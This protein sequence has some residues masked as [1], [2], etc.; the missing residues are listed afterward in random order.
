HL[1]SYHYNGNY[2][3]LEESGHVSHTYAYDSLHNRT[4]HN[5][6][7]Y[8]V[9]ALHSVLHDGKQQ[10]SYDARGN[11]TATGDTHYQYDGLDRLIEVSSP[12]Q[13][14][15]YSYDAFDRRIE[16]KQYTLEA[17]D[18]KLEHSERYI[19]TGQ[20]EIGCVDA[21]GR[22]VQ[23][24]VLGEGLGAEIGAAVAIELENFLHVPIHDHR[25]NVVA[26]LSP[27]GDVV[28][29]YR[30]DAYGNEEIFSPIDSGNPWRF[31][32]KRVDPETGLVY[33]GRRYYDPTIGKWLTHD[34]L[35][36]KAGPNL[37]A[38]VLNNPMMSFD[39][40]GLFGMR[41]AAAHF[42]AKQQRANMA[43]YR[44][45]VQSLN[46][47]KLKN[48]TIIFTNGI[49]TS[50]EM[51]LAHA[52]YL[53]DCLGG[54]DVT[55]VYNPTSGGPLPGEALRAGIRRADGNST[56][57]SDLL[58]EFAE[59]VINEKGPDH[60]VV[61]AA[62][63]EGGINTSNGLAAA[64]PKIT[65]QVT[66]VGVCPGRIIDKNLCKDVTNIVNESPWR[67]LVPYTDRELW[68][69]KKD[70]EY[71]KRYNLIFCSSHP[72]AHSFDH[73]F[74]SPSYKSELSDAINKIIEKR[75]NQ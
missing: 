39:L 22:I 54:C 60:D 74:Q 37:Y 1:N 17:S 46:I 31:S 41:E 6:S 4:A 29:S 10:Y 69:S 55:L 32:S 65:N 57:V 33:F 9:N 24:R 26:L 20:N 25:G 44:P 58:M 51:A 48:A 34:P 70:P 62:F 18:W 59:A 56:E 67:D 7:R 3:L 36:L 19:Y 42:E 43:R 53:S 73:D 50:P 64:D 72:D 21:E 47:P 71:A 49:C 27:D 23:L 11:R 2:Q 75:E 63:S 30:Y 14:T 8:Q 35:G 13:K 66:C 40:Y 45:F 38:Y 5:N 61:I 16:K 52:E 68:K 12:S 15:T 28:E